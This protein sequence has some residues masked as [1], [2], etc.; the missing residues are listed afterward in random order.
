MPRPLALSRLDN[1]IALR[2]TFA[3]PAD[4]VNKIKRILLIRDKDY[5]YYVYQLAEFL[6]RDGHDIQ[7]LHTYDD[8]PE[9]VYRDLITKTQQLGIKCYLVKPRA[10]FIEQKLVSL[11]SILRLI[12]KLNVIQPYKVRA[13]LRALKNCSAYDLIVAYDPPSL[14]LACRLFPEK[15]HKIINYSLEVDDETSIDF[16]RS[17]YVRGFRYFE[18]SIQS[19]LYALLIQDRFRAHVLLQNNTCPPGI[20]TIIFPVAMP[21]ASRHRGPVGPLPRN[22]ETRILFFG[23]IWSKELLEELKAVARRLERQQMLVI[24]TGRGTIRPADLSTEKLII[25]SDPIP[26][27]RINE[28]VAL[29]HIGLALYPERTSNN[30]RYTAFSSEKIARYIQCGIPFIAFKNEDYELLKLES[31]CCELVNGFSEVPGAISTI[32]R[33]YG[34]YQRGAFLAFERFYRLENTGAELLAQIGRGLVD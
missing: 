25:S 26:F 5:C 28:Q 2:P 31:G 32:V 33:S 1:K 21:G 23:A 3:L 24:Q 13:A 17:R 11:A 16:K 6:S 34:A 9:P 12:C 18:R 7:V 4:F 29:A 15:L 27:D 19:K 14:F 8:D 30:S 10:S 22:H 20:R